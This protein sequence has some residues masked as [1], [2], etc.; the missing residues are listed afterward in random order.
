MKTEKK[1]TRDYITRIN[2]FVNSAIKKER[3]NL[4]KRA[5][6]KQGKRPCRAND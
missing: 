6:A 3:E 1:R 2:M 4:I 5:I